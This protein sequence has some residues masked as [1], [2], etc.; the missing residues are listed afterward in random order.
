VSTVA[1]TRTMDMKPSSTGTETST[2]P[3][4]SSTKKMTVSTLR[5]YKISEAHANGL[6]KQKDDELAAKTAAIDAKQAQ[7]TE[8]Q[9][10]ELLAR[11]RRGWGCVRNACLR[12]LELLTPLPRC[13]NCSHKAFDTKQK[14]GDGEEKSI[15]KYCKRTLKLKKFV[16]TVLHQELSEHP[17]K[18]CGF[19]TH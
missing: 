8:D 10:T 1:L 9:T 6:F 14:S 19:L 16:Y 3:R 17:Q 12:M 7:L 5:N 18:F 11:N 2:R 4:K 15:E 13:K